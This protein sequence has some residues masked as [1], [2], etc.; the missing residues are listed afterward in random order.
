MFIA[1][2]PADHSIT[3]ETRDLSSVECR[4][5]DGQQADISKTF[6]RTF[7]SINGR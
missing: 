1:D 4:W 7:Y 5:I 6:R 2:A 3:C